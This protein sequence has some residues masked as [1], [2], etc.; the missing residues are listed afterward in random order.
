MSQQIGTKAFIKVRCIDLGR[1]LRYLGSGSKLILNK[2]YWVRRTSFWPS[3]YEA[4]NVY[5]DKDYRGV[6]S[7]G[8]F[9]AIEEWRDKQINILI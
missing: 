2:V 1:D 8:C 3:G 7:K 5:D 6:Y 4:Y 9:I